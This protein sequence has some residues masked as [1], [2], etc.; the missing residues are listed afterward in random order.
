VLLEPTEE[1][2]LV[3]S[4]AALVATEEV[5]LEP[6][7]EVLLT[8]IPEEPVLELHEGLLVGVRVEVPLS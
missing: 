3:V 6:T 5:L 2:L 7:E 4:V 1:V 8:Q